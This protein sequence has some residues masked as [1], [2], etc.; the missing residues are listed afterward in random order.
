[1]VMKRILQAGI[2]IWVLTGDKL[3]T[4]INISYSCNMLS[5]SQVKILISG[6]SEFEV[7]VKL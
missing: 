1:M 5:D 2:K 3:E 6:E 4:A 7:S